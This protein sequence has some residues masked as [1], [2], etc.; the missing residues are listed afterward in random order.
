MGE[1][2]SAGERIGEPAATGLRLERK[3]AETQAKS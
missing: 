2:K 1:I 3:E